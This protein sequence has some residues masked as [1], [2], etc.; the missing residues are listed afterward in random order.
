MTNMTEQGSDFLQDLGEAARRNPV[1]AALIGMGVIWMF[2]GGGRTAFGAAGEVARR[3]RLDRL[4]D[5]AGEGL[6]AAS[7]TLKS[8]WKSAGTTV[9]SAADKM[10]SGAASAMDRATRFGREQADT[11]SGYVKSM[12]DSGAEMIGS[13]RSNLTEL[14]R[15]QPLALGAVGLAIGAGIAAALPSTEAEAE[16]FGETSDTFKEQAKEFAAEQTARAKTIAE[17]VVGAVTEEAR[18][19][20]L[21]VEGAKAAAGDMSS[22]VKRVLD[23]AGNGVSQ[24]VG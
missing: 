20:G 23:A 19:Q 10:Q 2:T 18:N 8:G 7:S 5:V 17:S 16:Y 6:E 1:S 3:T 22:K 11:L 9:S 4:P 24:R 13:V 14:F 15:A 21:T 12:P